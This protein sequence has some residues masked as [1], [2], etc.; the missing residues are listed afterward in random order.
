MTISGGGQTG[1]DRS[2]SI[3]FKTVYSLE[4]TGDEK[5]I[6]SQK[7]DIPLLV[8]IPKRVDPAAKYSEDESQAT[9]SEMSPQS[10]LVDPTAP[11][12]T[13]SS[14]TSTYK[15]CFSSTPVEVPAQEFTERPAT[16]PVAWLPVKD[17]IALLGLTRHLGLQGMNGGKLVGLEPK[18]IHRIFEL[19][20]PCTATC[21]FGSPS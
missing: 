20:D 17:P 14:P 16:P 8:L 7:A 3:S 9:D 18:V 21:K 12:P 1:L 2:L 6:R 19:L 10:T 15:T 5:P 13:H 11:P 4:G